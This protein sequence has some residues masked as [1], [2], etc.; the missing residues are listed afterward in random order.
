[1]F[2]KNIYQDDVPNFPEISE[3]YFEIKDEKTINELMN[4]YNS[5]KILIPVNG[6]VSNEFR[7]K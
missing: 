1:M 3:D 4:L 2:G 7:E 5:S 6:S